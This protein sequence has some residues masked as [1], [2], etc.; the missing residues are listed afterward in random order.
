M[1]KRSR[2]ISVGFAG[3]V[4]CQPVSLSAPAGMDYVVSYAT[5]K[6]DQDLIES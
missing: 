1:L 3:S 5:T 6:K 4:S 2:S